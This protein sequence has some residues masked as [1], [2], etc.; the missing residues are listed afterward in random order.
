M[1]RVPENWTKMFL[2]DYFDWCQ[3]LLL[4]RNN[5]FQ[6]NKYLKTSYLLSVNFTPRP[7]ELKVQNTA[8]EIH[9]GSI[10]SSL[11]LHALKNVT[12]NLHYF[13]WCY[14]FQV[15]DPCFNLQYLYPALC[16]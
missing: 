11:L 16:L 2:W 9:T 10:C 8:Q 3:L 12:Q 6:I 5:F 7:F 13:C 15:L 14:F 4:F 1:A